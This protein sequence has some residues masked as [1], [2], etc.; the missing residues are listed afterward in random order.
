MVL[1]FEVLERTFQMV[2]PQAEDFVTDFYNSLFADAPELKPLFIGADTDL[3]TQ[4]RNLIVSSRYIVGN[5][6]YPDILRKSLRELGAKHLPDEMTQEHY[7]VVGTALFK[8]LASY[9]GKDWTPDVEKAWQGAYHT[10]SETML[11]GAQEYRQSRLQAASVAR[12]YK[13]HRQKE[14]PSLSLFGQPMRGVTTPASIQATPTVLYSSPQT[15]GYAFSRFSLK[16][17]LLIGLGILTVVII[18][19][20][21]LTHQKS[22]SPQPAPNSQSLIKELG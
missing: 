22:N 17:K 12:E 19:I 6:R 8:T 18:G 10:M 7:S 15:G 13:L 9:L 2:A 16:T 1:K 20:W 4:K 5:M 14:S 21:V 3:V 11:E